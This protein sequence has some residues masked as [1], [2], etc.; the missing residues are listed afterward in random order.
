MWPLSSQVGI[1]MLRLY[2]REAGYLRETL[3]WRSQGVDSSEAVANSDKHFARR[4]Q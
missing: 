4:G 3:C 2:D 1:L